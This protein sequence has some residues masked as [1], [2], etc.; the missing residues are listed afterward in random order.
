LI[1]VLLCVFALVAG[2]SLSAGFIIGV[3]AQVKY[4]EE[5]KFIGR[6]EVVDPVQVTD[7]MVR[8]LEEEE[9]RQDTLCS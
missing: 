5:G 3:R 7:R 6:V 1:T 2:L 4:K 8:E 9:K